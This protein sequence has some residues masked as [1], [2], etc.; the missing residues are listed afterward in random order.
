MPGDQAPPLVSGGLGLK[1]RHREI[2]AHKADVNARTMM[3]APLC[4]GGV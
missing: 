2:L 3:A 4:R 1:Q